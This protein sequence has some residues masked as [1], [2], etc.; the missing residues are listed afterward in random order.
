MY[1]RVMGCLY[2]VTNTVNGKQYV[3][4]TIHTVSHRKSHHETIARRKTST[5]ALHRAIAWKSVP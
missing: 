3:G 4:K 2:L 5:Y 1:N